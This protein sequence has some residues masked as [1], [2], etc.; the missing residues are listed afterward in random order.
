MEKK[1]EVMSANQT[2]LVKL[3]RS[4][5]I[6]GNKG[7][8]LMKSMVEGPEMWRDVS[9]AQGGWQ[10]TQNRSCAVVYEHL[11]LRER[12]VHKSRDRD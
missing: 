3:Q 4:I 9:E 6:S 12:N 10:I 7:T 1:H 2:S 5:D 8:F 11:G